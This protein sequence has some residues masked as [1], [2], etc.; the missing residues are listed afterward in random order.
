MTDHHSRYSR[1]NEDQ[2]NYET[3]DFA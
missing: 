2:L 3:T 1:N